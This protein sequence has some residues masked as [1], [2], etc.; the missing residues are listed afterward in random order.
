VR[1]LEN[2]VARIASFAVG[3]RVEAADV[4]KV[5]DSSRDGE[6]RWPSDSSPDEDEPLLPYH[7]AKERAVSA[8]ERAYA[9]RLLRAHNGRIVAAARAANID[10]KSLSRLL[11]RVGLRGSGLSDG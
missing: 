2:V 5:V 11:D 6:A 9:Q 1:E 7:E 10:R 3:P 8:F 4:G